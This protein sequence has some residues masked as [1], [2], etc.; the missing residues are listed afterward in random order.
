MIRRVTIN[1]TDL[2]AGPELVSDP[3]VGHKPNRGIDS[4]FH[5]HAAPTCLCYSMTDFPGF[6]FDDKS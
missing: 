3:G 1:Q 6:N 5:A 2:I 4:I